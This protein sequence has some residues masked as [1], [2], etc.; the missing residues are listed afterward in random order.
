MVHSCVETISGLP[1][2][3][4][5]VPFFMGQVSGIREDRE[6]LIGLDKTCPI[7]VRVS[8]HTAG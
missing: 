8:C 2:R 4:A 5:G 6:A 1:L 7:F 3:H